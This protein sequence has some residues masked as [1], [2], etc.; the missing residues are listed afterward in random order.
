VNC[1]LHIVNGGKDPLYPAASVEPLVAMFKR[2]GVPY[3]FKVYPD[4]GHDVSWWP[5]E[6][7]GTRRG[8]PRIRAGASRAL[9]VGDRTHRSL[10]PVPLAR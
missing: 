7:A 8:S 9:L 1:P 6:R 4:A 2:A 10:Q 5:Q 3:E